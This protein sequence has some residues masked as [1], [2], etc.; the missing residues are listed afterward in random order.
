MEA[1]STQNPK[2][3]ND[4]EVTIDRLLLMLL[5]SCAN[6]ARS[7]WGKTKLEKLI[8]FSQYSMMKTGNKSLNYYFYRWYYGPYSEQVYGDLDVLSKCNLVIQRDDS[9]EIITTPKGQ[10][11]LERFKSVFN[12]NSDTY[13][14]I[15]EITSEYRTCDADQIRDAIYNTIVFGTKNLYV[16]DVGLGDPLLYKLPEEKAKNIFKISSGKLETLSILFMPNFYEQIIRARAEK[17]ILPY[18]PL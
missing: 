8:Y 4:R 1:N 11:I 9:R 13:D 3:R 14:T 6:K 5:I 7:L 17:V 2:D 12:E 10:E 18:K 15:K 16:R